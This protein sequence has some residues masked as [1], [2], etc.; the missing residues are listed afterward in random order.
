MRNPCPETSAVVRT[1]ITTTTT[2]ATTVSPMRSNGPQIATWVVRL[3]AL[4]LI[5]TAPTSVAGQAVLTAAQEAAYDKWM[6][7]WT[8]PKTPSVSAT[9]LA[10]GKRAWVWTGAPALPDLQLFD[11][12]ANSI[13]PMVDIAR[14][15]TMLART[16]GREPALPGVPFRAFEFTNATQTAIRFSIDRRDFVLNLNT[17][18]LEEVDS[19]SDAQ[20]RL[21]RAQ[22]TRRAAVSGWPV[23]LD[24]IRSP[25]GRMFAH[26]KDHNVW[27]RSAEDGRLVR[28]T[29][30]GIADYEWAADEVDDLNGQWAF[31]S[32]DGQKLAVRKEDNRQVAKMPLLDYD[33][34]GIVRWARF[35]LMGGKRPQP[36]LWVLDPQTLQHTRVDIGRDADQQILMMGWRPD[37][38]ELLYM[39]MNRAGTRSELCA[40][41]P[42]TGAARVILREDNDFRR[43]GA[44]TSQSYRFLANGTHFLARSDRDGWYHLYL[45]DLRGT[46]IR[47]L[48]T[49]RWEVQNVVTV[50]EKQGWVYF[51]G[52]DD[53][54]APYDVHLYRVGLDG[55]GFKR[56]TAAPGFHAVRV[57]PS[58]DFFVDRHSA[59]NRPWQVDI[60]RT[61]GTFVRTLSIADTAG[62][63]T[64]GWLAPETFTVKSDDGVTDLHGVLWKPANFDPARKYPVIDYIYAGP[65]APIVPRHFNLS[66]AAVHAQAMAQLGFITFMVDGRGTERRGRAFAAWTFGQSGRYEIPDHVA[67]LRQLAAQRPY[68]DLQR[69]GITGHSWGGHFAVRA[70][71]QAP[72]VYHVAVASA[73]DTDLRWFTYQ[74]ESYAQYR[75]DLEFASNIPLADRLKGKLLIVHGTSDLN[76]P[77]NVTMQMTDALI[78]HGK[79]FDMLVLPGRDHD[80]LAPGPLEVYLRRL[81][82]DY[83]IEHLKP[84]EFRAR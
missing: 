18:A 67:A 56:L 15:R 17:N 31:W 68:M 63:S 14:L 1:T 26:L 25:D 57:S 64:A 7:F 58:G 60:R 79:R 65:G 24:E 30:D 3:S 23:D 22:P 66:S 47:Q 19:L 39:R 32:P 76:V 49:G 51:Q 43:S 40:A 6:G 72:E 84:A 9:W 82:R 80:I 27:L 11:A 70:L 13:S 28:L 48:T 61:D 29:D 77:F 41:N 20:R 34:A 36:E 81:T 45:Y 83:F 4:L 5:M 10:D 73:P 33:R 21:Q 12:S 59:L 38:S 54:S 74:G 8:W 53:P 16:L 46:L 42:S 50:D 55:T 78:R 35:G 62:F 71:L 75:G 52:S 44:I 69:V 2:T 37:G